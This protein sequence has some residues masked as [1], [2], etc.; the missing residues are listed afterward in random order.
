MRKTILSDIAFIFPVMLYYVVESLIVSI[1][2][3]FVWRL[4]LYNS[5]GQIGYF[6]IAGGY[7]IIKMLLFNVFNLISGLNSLAAPPQNVDLGEISEDEN[8]LTE[9]DFR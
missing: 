3:F 9:K 1:F 6:Q 2:I 4:T 8:V 7:W 5:L